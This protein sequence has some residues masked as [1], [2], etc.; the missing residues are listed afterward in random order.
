MGYIFINS[1][2]TPDEAAEIIRHE[3]NHL[4]RNHFLD[5]IFI[6]IIKV[7]PVV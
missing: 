3:E 6:D 7:I 4:K 1:R 5:I 2:L